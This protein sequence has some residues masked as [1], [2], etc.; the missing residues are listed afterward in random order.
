MQNFV[1]KY[2]QFINEGARL[3][4]PNF[5]KVELSWLNDPKLPLEVLKSNNSHDVTGF[6]KIGITSDGSFQVYYGLTIDPKRNIQL[7]NEDPLFKITLDELKKS[8]ILNSKKGISDFV[9]RTAQEIIQKKR[10][11]D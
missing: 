7:G 2:N 6:R 10:K 3:V 1:K 4:G 9:T 5:D 8:N 11:I